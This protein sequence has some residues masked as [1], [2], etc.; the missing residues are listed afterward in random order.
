MTGCLVGNGNLPCVAFADYLWLQ[1]F[2]RPL[3]LDDEVYSIAR[4]SLLFRASSTKAKAA[5]ESLSK[6]SA[7]NAIFR[8]Q[9]GFN[10]R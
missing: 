1:A 3:A 8:R 4:L 6:L 7:A 2:G 9:R 5:G 10:G